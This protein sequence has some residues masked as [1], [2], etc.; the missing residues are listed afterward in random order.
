MILNSP[1]ICW[2]GAVIVAPANLKTDSVQCHKKCS[3]HFSAVT[4]GPMFGCMFQTVC[5]PEVFKQSPATSWNFGSDLKITLN[6]LDII[7]GLC[8]LLQL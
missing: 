1:N 4:C 2:S 6:Y 7:F 5:V 8:E 3:N